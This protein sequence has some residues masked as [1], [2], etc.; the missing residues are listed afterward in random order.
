MWRNITI[1]SI[2]IVQK[3]GSVN[4]FDTFLV[5]R[6]VVVNEIAKRAD[7]LGLKIAFAG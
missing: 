4:N 3:D 1:R 7:A 6:Q 2:V 5:D